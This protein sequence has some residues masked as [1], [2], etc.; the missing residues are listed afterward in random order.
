[1]IHIDLMYISM[2]SLLP[3]LFLGV[4]YFNKFS[5][6]L[7]TLTIFLCIYAIFESITYCYFI[8]N[9]NNMKLFHYFTIVEFIAIM[10][11]YWNIFKTKMVKL[12]ITI[13]TISYSSYLV[14]DLS[15][16]NHVVT[17]NSVERV[18]EAIFLLA[19]FT[20]YFIDERRNSK[21]KHLEE[22][23]HFILTAGLFLYFLGTILLFYFSNELIGQGLYALW[24]IH[25]ILNVLLN[26]TYSVV[27][28]KGRIFKT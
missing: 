23:N 27:L 9:K 24:T 2:L 8:Q 3:P 15:F 22:S 6:A 19:L 28:W 14:Y 12:F 18:I 20:F 7:K 5:W 17:F 4:I 11:I 16:N 10:M 13:T 21:I 1:M 25:S 26:I